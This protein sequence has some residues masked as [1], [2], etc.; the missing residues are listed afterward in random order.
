[1]AESRVDRAS[2]KLL[3]CSVRR[4]SVLMTRTLVAL[5]D[6]CTQSF[7]GMCA[8]TARR[9]RNTSSVHEINKKKLIYCRDSA[10]DAD[11]ASAKAFITPFR[12]IQG[13]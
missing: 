6:T 5:A 11:T 4:S 2:A 1:M 3:E 13:H 8:C 12:V 9:V 7:A 10:V